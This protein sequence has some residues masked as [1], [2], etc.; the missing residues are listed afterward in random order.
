MIARFALL[1]FFVPVYSL[2]QIPNFI[3]FQGSLANSSSGAPTNGTVSMTLSIYETG[4]GNSKL[5]FE[6][7][8]SVQVV[9]GVFNILLG[10]VTPL[11]PADFSAFRFLEIEVDSEV[12]GSRVPLMSVPFAFHA[13]NAEQQRSSRISAARET[14]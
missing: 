1:A 8:P 2:A 6:T 12:I 5:W 3:S 7:Q 10:S 9:D 4:G 11:N 14:S 13:A